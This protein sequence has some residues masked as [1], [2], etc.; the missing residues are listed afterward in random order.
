MITLVMSVKQ[1]RTKWKTGKRN[2]TTK[3]CN[4]F[5]KLLGILWS[6][7]EGILLILK[8]IECQMYIACV[9]ASIVVIRKCNSKAL[10]PQ[11]CSWQVKETAAGT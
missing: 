1:D 7:H 5:I 9:L 6:S 8:S 4:Y 3:N 2:G 10:D 11:S